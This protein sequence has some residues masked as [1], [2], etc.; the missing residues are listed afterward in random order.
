MNQ[1]DRISLHRLS[2][3]II[4]NA[5]LGA[6]FFRLRFQWSPAIP[7]RAGQFVTLRITPRPVPLLRRPFAFSGFSSE[8]G[9]ASIIVKRRGT[10]TD[11]LSRIK[12]GETLDLL[13]PLGNWFPEPAANRQA[14]LLAG[15]IGLGPL[16]FFARQ[17]RESGRKA[18]L[19]FGCRTDEELPILG[20]LQNADTVTCTDDGSSGYAGTVVDYL[21]QR[22]P[23]QPQD[24]TVYACGP[25]PMLKA[26]AEYAHWRDVPCWVSMEQVMGCAMGACMGC[27]VRVKSGSGY[28]RVCREG[29]VFDSREIEWT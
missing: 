26:A 5:S 23:L 15:G 2:P 8:A 29:P 28:A 16:L 3:K 17:L 11:M 19:V 9:E 25:S 21:Q 13:G 24:I 20:D 22:L 1:T 4:D 18:M 14:V 7:I 12:A 6:G 27:V 10:A